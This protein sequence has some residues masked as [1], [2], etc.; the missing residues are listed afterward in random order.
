MKKRRT[1]EQW[2]EIL[3]RQKE[4]G[5]TDAK[6]AEE[7]GVSVSGLRG[8]RQRLK[9]RTE[10]PQPLIEVSPFR[11]MGELWVHLPNGLIVEVPAGWPADQLAAVVGHLRAL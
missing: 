2:R 4:T 10:S 7:T 5:W 6:A 1:A 3:A 9:N 11:P 8:W